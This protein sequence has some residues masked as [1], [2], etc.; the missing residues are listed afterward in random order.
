MKLDRLYKVISLMSL[1]KDKKKKIINNIY[2][3]LFASFF[4]WK[5]KG[6]VFDIYL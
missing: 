2:V 3:F 4:L 1:N 5:K 6:N